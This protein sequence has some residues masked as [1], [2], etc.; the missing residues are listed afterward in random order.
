MR[1]TLLTL[2]ALF[3]WMFVFATGTYAQRQITLYA[4]IV[5]SSGESVKTLNPEDVTV[6]ENGVEAKI[7]KVE[8]I[9][10]TS[11]VQLLIDNGGAVGSNNLGQLRTGVRG[12]IEALPPGIEVTL[13]T[14]SPQPRFVVRATTDRQ[15]QLAGIDK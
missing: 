14:T 7:L 15:A 6:R 11:K 5:D 13:V 2:G 9:D 4:S 8:P 1:S 10:W 12:L 3:L